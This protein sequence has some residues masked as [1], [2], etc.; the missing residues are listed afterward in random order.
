MP[1]LRVDLSARAGVGVSDREAFDPL[2][3]DWYRLTNAAGEPLLGMA[4]RKCGRTWYPT[5]TLEKIG[6]AVA[7][8][9]LRPMPAVP[10]ACRSA[11]HARGEDNKTMVTDE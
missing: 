7:P 8:V 5:E 4:C 9:R 2:G 1:V 6:R 10:G 11:I 3:H